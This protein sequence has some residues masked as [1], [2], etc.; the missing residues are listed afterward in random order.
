[1]NSTGSHYLI[2]F[3]VLA[4]FAW[5]S[6]W[7]LSPNKKLSG[8]TGVAIGIIFEVAPSYGLRGFRKRNAR[9]I[10][11][12]EDQLFHGSKLVNQYEKWLEEGRTVT[13]EHEEKNPDNNRI[14]GYAQG[15]VSKE[16]FLKIEKMGYSSVQLNDQLFIKKIFDQHQKQLDAQFGIFSRHGDTLI[17]DLF[18]S[19]QNCVFIFAKDSLGKKSLRNHKTGEVYQ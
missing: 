18:D 6:F 10:F 14:I 19:E 15:T 2:F 12:V 7:K 4:A 3:M 8:S 11:K 16:I 13:V 5:F 9:Y 17:V 1:M